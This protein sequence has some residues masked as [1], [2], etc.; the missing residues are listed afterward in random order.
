MEGSMRYAWLVLLLQYLSPTFA[1]SQ[2]NQ[3]PQ[4]NPI[5]NVQFPTNLFENGRNAEPK[6]FMDTLAF[7][8]PVS[9]K[10]ERGDSR[11]QPQVDSSCRTETKAFVYGNTFVTQTVTVTAVVDMLENCD[12]Q[13]FNPYFCQ[14]TV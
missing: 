7:A 10:T 5:P 2:S 14:G 6:M 3:A 8:T 13:N 4:I 11:P 1:F 9:G 12:D